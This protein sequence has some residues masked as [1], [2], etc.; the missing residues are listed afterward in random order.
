MSFCYSH[1]F[2]LQIIHTRV[3]TSVTQNVWEHWILEVIWFSLT[4]K[5]GPDAER[6]GGWHASLR[7][8]NQKP[9]YNAGEGYSFYMMLQR[10]NTSRQELK[11]SSI[12]QVNSM[13]SN[14]T[15]ISTSYLKQTGNGS[16]KKKTYRIYG[17]FR[18]STICQELAP[19]SK[20]YL[21]WCSKETA[22]MII[23]D[24]R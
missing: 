11:L 3:Q 10:E 4:L 7:A 18:P 20:D 16:G 12:K 23:P 19:A 22:N 5:A 21:F 13:G 2:Q 24:K 1:K 14:S 8:E 15:S 17:L 6:D 9:W